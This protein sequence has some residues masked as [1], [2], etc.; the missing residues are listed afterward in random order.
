MTEENWI[1]FDNEDENTWPKENQFVEVPLKKTNG[2]IIIRKGIFINKIFHVFLDDLYYDL[3]NIDAR[4]GT[5]GDFLRYFHGYLINDG[6][7]KSKEIKWRYKNDG[8]N[9]YL[10]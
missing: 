3:E 6:I 2:C 4:K 1:K 10:A 9:I 7:S 5:P 8:K